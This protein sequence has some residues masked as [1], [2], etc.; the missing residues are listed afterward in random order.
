MRDLGITHIY[1]NMAYADQRFRD[2]L[3]GTSPYSPQESESM[4]A[5]LNLKWKLLVAD[6]ANRRLI[7]DVEG[8]SELGLGEIVR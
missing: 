4:S 1:L 8:D 6:A 2:A 3:D 5:D 7:R